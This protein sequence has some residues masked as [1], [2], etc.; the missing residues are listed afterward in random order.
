MPRD[1]IIQSPQFFET[2]HQLSVSF[3]ASHGSCETLLPHKAQKAALDHVLNGTCFASSGSAC[4]LVAQQFDQCPGDF[5][6][7]FTSANH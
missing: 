4:S 3:L 7:L 5:I 2:S 6:T 1:I